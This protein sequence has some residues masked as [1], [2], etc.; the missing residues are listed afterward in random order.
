[1]IDFLEVKIRD[2]DRLK[3]FCDDLIEC[4]NLNSKSLIPWYYTPETT[5]D[6]FPQ[7]S[8][9]MFARNDDRSSSKFFDFFSYIIYDTFRQWDLENNGCIR[10]CLNMTYHIPGY[11]CFD[12]HVDNYDDHYSTILYLNESDGNTLIFDSTHE[13]EDG[14]SIL[15]KHEDDTEQ[16]YELTRGCLFHDRLNWDE[17]PLKIKHEVEPE[18]GK[19]LIFNG[20]YLHSVAPP[21]PGNL[22][23]VSVYNVRV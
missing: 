18:F 19:M 8:H 7:L 16:R 5:S 11:K 12:P 22:R 9:N 20:K 21:S 13:H 10:S 1:M 23:I 17:K 2:I 14:D 15:C 3:K 6:K 4:K